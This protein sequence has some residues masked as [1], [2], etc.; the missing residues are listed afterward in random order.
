MNWMPLLS[1]LTGA[2]IGIAATLIAD[3]NRWRREEARHALEVRREVYTEYVSALK[4]AGEEIRAV[5]LGDHM[6]ES[7]RD[8]AVREA[9]RGTGIYT[10]SERLWLVGPPQV[11]E[12]G[13]EAFHCLRAIRDAYAR[14]VAVGSA[15][16]AP[17]IERRRKAMAQM[18]RL[19]REDLGIGPLGIE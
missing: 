2:V 10:A 18:R 13:N 3:R 19:M 15:D 6:S 12:V 5:A 1:T 16:D 11:V 9:V 17:L 4:A 7:A 14:G 8:A